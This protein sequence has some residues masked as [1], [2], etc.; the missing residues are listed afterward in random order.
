MADVGVLNLQIHDNSEQSAAGLDHLVDALERV[1]TAV[2]SGIKL[3]GINTQIRNIAKAVND[4]LTDSTFA[5]IEQLADSLSKLQ[6]IGDIRIKIQNAGE[7]KGVRESIRET[8]ES[9]T[10]IATGFEQ[11][12][13]R[14]GEMAETVKD[15][16]PKLDFSKFDP[17]LLPKGAL[18]QTMEDLRN[19]AQEIYQF[20]AA[21]KDADRIVTQMRGNNGLDQFLKNGQS[22]ASQASSATN[23]LKAATASATNE[24]YKYIDAIKS[25]EEAELSHIEKIIQ[26]NHRI[27]EAREAMRDLQTEQNVAQPGVNVQMTF[28][29]QIADLDRLRGMLRGAEA[30]YN[31]LV[32]ALGSTDPKTVQ[33][34]NVVAR[35][36]REVE[37][38][39]QAS[40]SASAATQNLNLGDL[41]AQMTQTVSDIQTNAFGNLPRQLDEASA[42]A[43]TLT[44][45]LAEVDGELHQK[46]PDAEDAARGIFTFNG[47]LHDMRAALRAAFPHLTS[48]FARIKSIIT[49]RAITAA[50]RTV[51]S[52]FKEG[53]ENVYRYSS[54][55]HG[56]FA[57]SMDSAASSLSLFKNSIGAAVAPLIEMLIPYLQQAINWL[58]NFINT[59]N[60]FFALM[61]GQSTWTRAVPQTE[62]AFSK[63]TKAAKGTSNAIKE[64]LADWDE[65]NIIQSETSGAGA[66]AGAGA[67]EDY[68]K[69]FE[70]VSVFDDKVKDAVSFIRDNFETIKS[71]ALAIGAAI[72]G[73]KLSHA[74]IQGLGAIGALAA[75]ISLSIIGIKWAYDAA[76]Q[77]G[78]NGEFSDTDVLETI[79]GIAASA[80]GGTLVATALFGSSA[81]LIGFGI[82]LG[83]GILF[84]LIGYIK[85]SE[86]KKDI[87]SW[88][89]KSLTPEEIEAEVQ[90]K[91]QFDVNSEIEVMSVNITNMNGARK[92]FEEKIKQFNMSLKEA[93][94]R[95]NVEINNKETLDAVL[96]A[97]KD[98]YATIEAV[99]NLIDTNEHNITYT[100]GQ[101]EFK[102]SEG[103]TINESILENVKVA[104]QTVKDYLI[105][106]GNELAGYIKKGELEG[107]TGDE[108]E[109]ALALMERERKILELRNEFQEQFER[110]LEINTGIAGIKVDD[111]TGMID[112]DSALA[113]MNREKELINEWTEKA[114]QS[115]QSEIDGLVSIASIAAAAAQDALEQS[116]Y[117]YENET[118][119][120]L[121]KSAKDL[122][123]TAEK[124][125]KDFE[126]E[127]QNRLD[128]TIKHMIESWSP[129]LKQAY[130]QMYD[131]I[132]SST[133][134]N[135]PHSGLLFVW[136]TKAFGGEWE[137]ENHKLIRESL[138]KSGITETGA[139]MLESIK[140]GLKHADT[141]GF[142]EY[143][144]DFLKGNVWDLITEDGKKEIAKNFQ[145]ITESYEDA[146][147]LFKATF[148]LDDDTA[149][150]YISKPKYQDVWGDQLDESKRAIVQATQEAK[151]ERD[152][153]LD[154]I[155]EEW[156]ELPAE[157]FKEKVEALYGK[158]GKDT[159]LGTLYSNFNVTSDKIEALEGLKPPVNV[160]PYTDDDW[161]IMDCIDEEQKVLVQ[162][163]TDDDWDILDGMDEKPQVEVE[164][165][166]D[167][168]W[169]LWDGMEDLKDGID[170]EVGDG[171]DEFQE[172]ANDAN[173]ILEI[174]KE[175]EK[176]ILGAGL[177]NPFD[178]LKQLND[179]YIN[180]NFDAIEDL[181]DLIAEQGI[182]IALQMLNNYLKGY[183]WTV[184][185]KTTFNADQLI[186]N[187]GISDMPMGKRTSETN[188]ENEAERDDALV[189]GVTAGV[190]TA[191]ADQNDYFR[192]MVNW[193]STIA[194][195]TAAKNNQTPS[196][197]D[198]R[199]TSQ[200]VSLFSNISGNTV[201]G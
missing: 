97:A 150:K 19:G 94:L 168:D 184:G 62:K 82:G 64:L 5:R 54:A 10:G 20:G 92:L 40:Q 181:K 111:K 143:Y 49:R 47:S 169:D 102:D 55:I 174:Y 144:L 170:V 161:D 73:W 180:G 198:G 3:S 17:A 194:R 113:E 23:D 118:Y 28:E 24:R 130:G 171:G 39:E 99:N 2:G 34:A 132:S 41:P 155:S 56:S 160:E 133:T 87:L 65:L 67:A 107:L 183:D 193:L 36:R 142:T 187:A 172:L 66:G 27:Q 29:P 68:L 75:G 31:S 167:E 117:D 125:K 80:L 173:D 58:I 89:D 4:S 185:R 136:L 22:A 163:Y 103:K 78:L 96:Q 8:G 195:N 156:L 190:R 108:Q 7:I 105:G 63:Q 88:G 182:D 35:I 121:Q 46:R 179:L 38:L 137:S 139:M 134:D 21:V 52:G 164:P 79:G 84:T 1:R 166:V 83:V 177:S 74:L 192:T 127:V 199:Y 122:L 119:K 124:M 109:T 154:A 197:D 95:V 57:K 145:D 14:V 200:S 37:A 120:N 135:D 59:V 60:Q 51:V 61:N 157:E 141:S 162:P 201:N 85:G 81:S 6:G 30:Q 123:D 115:V 110:D 129:L 131:T 191:N 126:T 178:A 151:Q 149:S 93:K 106:I 176:T 72:L 140:Y 9:V 44:T 16:M 101:I 186:G 26:E 159:V 148:N 53:V 70:E 98:A 196:S 91:F 32:N 50:L 114:K 158:F 138:E 25:A 48:L 43:N 69:M 112:R 152:S 189:R 86:E 77:G 45:G 116:G 188:A 128:P 146:Y 147:E 42:C 18:G 13:R 71:A 76:F 11:V 175:I 33:F 12:E 90:S 15:T 100:L 165:Y 104:D 153:V